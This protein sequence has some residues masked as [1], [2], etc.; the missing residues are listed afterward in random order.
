MHRRTFLKSSGLMAA[1]WQAA[2]QQKRNSLQRTNHIKIS[3]NMYSFNKQLTDGEMTLEESIDFCSDLGFDAV[4]PTGYYFTGYPDVPPD[5]ELYRIKR[6]AFV[7]GLDIS[8][9]GIRTDFAVASAGDRREQID[10]TRRWIEVAAKLDAP[11]LRVFAGKTLPE[12]YSREQ[13]FDWIIE[14]LL[15]CV[16]AATD[17][18]VMI[19][20]QN[21][22]DVLRSVEDVRY[23]LDAIES[24]WFALN[25]DIGSCRLSDPYAEIA[26]LASYAQTW[27]IKEHVYREEVKEALDVDALAH[28][29]KTSGYRGYLP[30]ETLSPTDPRQ[31]LGSFK[32]EVIEALEL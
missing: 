27:Q 10:F 8:G 17:H 7:Q 14:A 5:A 21:H 2:P 18:G 26:R 32:E 6:R 13:V 29:L 15:T 12:G 23:I 19:V 25:L 24:D 3:C 11:V 9:T 4:D 20:L 28:V 16:S 1:G 22:F 30:L 31:R